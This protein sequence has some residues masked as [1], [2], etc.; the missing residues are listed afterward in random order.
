MKKRYENN[1]G[2]LGKAPDIGVG[3]SDAFILTVSLI[4]FVFLGWTIYS[5]ILSKTKTARELEA[6][7]QETSYEDRLAQAD[8]ST[9][10]RSQ[11][12]AR[13]RIMMKK[14]RLANTNQ[15]NPVHPIEVVDDGD[16]QQQQQQNLLL[17]QQQQQHDEGIPPFQDESHH[18]TAHNMLSR[19][20]RQKAAKQV[21][22]QERKMF[23]E[24]RRKEQQEA[25]NAAKSK[26]REKEKML[27]IQ[28]ERD[29]KERQEQ[30]HADEIVKYNAWK[31][32]FV[33]NNTNNDEE[34]ITVQ[35]WIQEMKQ[36][37]IVKLKDLANRFR[38]SQDR[39]RERIIELINSSRISGIIE[40]G[41]NENFIYLPPD[42]M[43][44]LASFVKLRGKI[45]TKE[46]ALHIQE[47]LQLSPS[48]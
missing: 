11:R 38:V 39:V 25:L 28:A 41:E 35:E 19:K 42:D 23:E 7:D 18:S 9:L 17:E 32:L 1:D 5:I 29:R 13:A 31:I 44:R 30:R 3:V 24:D 2:P 33:E 36:N 40:Q 37:R 45:T 26:K 16:E 4:G 22:L 10:N 14:N 15:N 43:S 27:A 47:E 6:E 12:R 20:E 21:E 46:F 34:S 8:V 48:E